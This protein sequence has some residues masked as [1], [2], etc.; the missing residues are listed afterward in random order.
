VGTH[1]GTGEPMSALATTQAEC[2]HQLRQQFGWQP[3]EVREVRVLHGQARRRLAAL[4]PQDAAA[5][6]ARQPLGAG[7]YVTMNALSATGERYAA[8]ID[9]PHRVRFA[10]DFDPVRPAGTPATDA[11]VNAARALGVEVE[12][13]LLACGWAAALRMDSGNGVHCYWR[14]DLATA[15]TLPRQLLQA[16]D[17]RY[18]NH[19]VGVDRTIHN[20]AR[21]M[22]A[23]CC[24]NCK[25]TATPDAPHRIARVTR[26][27]EPGAPALTD[28]D[29]HAALRALGVTEP[30]PVPAKRVPTPR[31]HMGCTLRQFDMGAWLAHHCIEHTG[32]KEWRCADGIGTRWVLTACPFNAMH[33]RG[34]ACITQA[35]SGA[36]AFRCQ[37]HGCALH[38]WRE[39]RE[40]NEGVRV[41]VLDIFRN[42]NGE[43]LRVA[44]EQTY[45]H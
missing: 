40:M 4:T 19:E 6:A 36:I 23:A 7:V 20:P 43:T 9:V 45:G 17:A 5:F 22:R 12:Q 29:F 14:V 15:S 8:D 37:H 34:E 28:E 26:D 21:I 27:G 41:D 11:Q 30:A 3:G 42:G 18:G 1:E 32:A 38:G 2:A 16:L 39:L 35:A 10:L 44:Q 33:N 25:G 24:W 13:F 31:R